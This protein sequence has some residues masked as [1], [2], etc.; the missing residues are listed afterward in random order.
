MNWSSDEEGI[1]LF[2][3]RADGHEDPS[4]YTRD[5]SS[6][7]QYPTTWL[8][9]LSLGGKNFK[10]TVKE[11][12]QKNDNCLWLCCFLKINGYI[13]KKILS[14]KG[15]IH[16]VLFGLLMRGQQAV[17]FGIC[18]K[19]QLRHASPQKR[20]SKCLNDFANQQLRRNGLPF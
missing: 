4:V 7:L 5:Q 10:N 15:R 19:T 9:Y 2:I 8:F 18:A 20:Q 6:M 1:Q 3:A 13:F 17:Q 12:K 14:L 11:N 16:R